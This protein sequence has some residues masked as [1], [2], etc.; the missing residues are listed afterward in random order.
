MF[1]VTQIVRFRLERR[2]RFRNLGFCG[3]DLMRT[4]TFD[5][6]S[7][8]TFNAPV[9]IYPEGLAFFPPFLELLRVRVIMMVQCICV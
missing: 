8:A 3:H 2:L 4:A 9:P 5:L 1:Q 7:T 6:M